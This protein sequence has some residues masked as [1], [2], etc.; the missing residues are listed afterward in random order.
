MSKLNGLYAITDAKLISQSNFLATVERAL[1][2]GAGIIQYRDKSNDQKKRLQQA[3]ALKKLCARQGAT[4]IINDDLELAKAVDADGV[5]IGIDD[6]PL[7]QARQ[8][9]GGN[10]I[11]GVSCYNQ[12]ELAQQAA[13]QGAD[14]IAFGSFF[15]SSTKPH[16]VPAELKLIR[17]AKQQFDLPVCA[18]GGITINNASPLLNAGADML[19]V[20][21]S[22]FGE[23]DPLAACKLFCQLINQKSQHD[24]DTSI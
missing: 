23:S 16:A 13:S 3:A 9:L 17:K 10:K 21:S 22:I 15:P 4:L 7:Q 20:V 14:Y 6:T 1:Q 18:I 11:I 8:S 2:G 19:A 12:F 24:G 5:H